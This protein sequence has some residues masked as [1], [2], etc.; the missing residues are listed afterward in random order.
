MMLKS[1]PDLQSIDSVWVRNL[2]KSQR[3]SIQTLDETAKSL[4]HKTKASLDKIP[5]VATNTYYFSKAKDAYAQ[6]L[7]IR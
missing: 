1:F 6:F 5:R 3:H 7:E 4:Y 2:A